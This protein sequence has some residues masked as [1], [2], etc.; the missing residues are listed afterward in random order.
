[1]TVL[2][3]TFLIIHLCIIKREIYKNKNACLYFVVLRGVKGDLRAV[4]VSLLPYSISIVVAAV[5]SVAVA[6]AVA[7]AAIVFAVVSVRCTA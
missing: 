3:L 6:V 2:G 4:G 5:V 1:M 7:V